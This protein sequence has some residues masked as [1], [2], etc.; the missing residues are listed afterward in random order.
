MLDELDAA[1]LV[2]ALDHVA[3]APPEQ[4]WSEL[5]TIFARLARLG[6]PRAADGLARWVAA[7]PRPAHWKGEVGARLAELGDLRAVELLAERLRRAPA[8]VYSQC[9]NTP[10]ATA[11]RNCPSNAWANDASSSRAP[12]SMLRVCAL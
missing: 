2:A 3:A 10:A 12:T 8:D 4:T 7:A 9:T 6:D 5:R 11:P 1:G